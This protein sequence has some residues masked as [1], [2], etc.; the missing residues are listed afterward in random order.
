MV[1]RSRA[2]TFGLR[3]AQERMGAL[4]DRMFRGK[5]PVSNLPVPETT[6]E[7]ITE[8]ELAEDDSEEVEQ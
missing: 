5:G 2:R 8:A 4:N 3:D 1:R 6:A 7:R